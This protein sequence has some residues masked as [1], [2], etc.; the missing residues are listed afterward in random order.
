MINII[1]F[2]LVIRVVDDVATWSSL[3]KCWT[4]YLLRTWTDLPYPQI[5]GWGRPSRNEH[6]NRPQTLRE[7]QVC[8]DVSD[9]LDPPP[10]VVFWVYRVY[11]SSRDQSSRHPPG[12]AP[13]WP[14]SSPG[15]IICSIGSDAAGSEFWV[16]N[17]PAPAAGGWG[18]AANTIRKQRR[19][20]CLTNEF[21]S[22]R[23]RLLKIRSESMTDMESVARLQRYSR[24]NMSR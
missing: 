23:L 16:S 7:S 21:K 12:S 10:P 15:S 24:Y 22:T 19:S 8:E 11:I 20:G 9:S 4:Y 13:M 5:L 3:G 17:S 14:W 18:W 6:P 2:K 1:I